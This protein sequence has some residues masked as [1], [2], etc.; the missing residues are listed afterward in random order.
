[1][2][3]TNMCAID[4]TSKYWQDISR[5]APEII[6]ILRMHLDSVMWYDL[7]N[8]QYKY[9][10]MKAYRAALHDELTIALYH[11]KRVAYFLQFNENVDEYLQ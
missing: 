2:N 4:L 7:F 6:S 9:D 1:M 10:Q 11:P 5:H 8:P 3:S